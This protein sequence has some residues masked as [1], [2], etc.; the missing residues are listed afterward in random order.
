[1]L[2]AGLAFGQKRYFQ[3]T[4]GLCIGDSTYL[5]LPASISNSAKITWITPKNIEYNT[6]RIN[7]SKNIGKYI[8]TVKEGT[9]ITKDSTVVMFMPRP[10]FNLRDTT[11]CK[12]VTYIA[13]P[14]EPKYRYNWSTGDNTPRLR[15]DNP[16][17]YWVKADNKGCFFTDTF[18]VNVVPGIQVSF[19]NEITFCLSEEQKPLKIITPPGTKVL[20]NTGAT[21]NTINATKEGKYWVKTESK[22]CGARF[23]S[24]KVILK[25]CDCEMLIPNSFTPNEDNKN[26]YFFPVLQ[27]DYS[28]YSFTVYDKWGNQIY[29]TN[30][31]NSKWDGRFKGNLC[32]EDIYVYKIE[33]TEKESGKKVNRSGRVS[34]IR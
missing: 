24:V 3:D 5:N 21:S 31:V 27:C 32:E 4:T 17:K 2:A 22:V 13:D 33:S 11:V 28:Y 1:V 9:K 18:R 10:N 26:D 14:K 12:G 8:V 6:K 29:T 15:I 34:L 7:A 19:Q 23:D 30:N 16:G 25:A 20:W